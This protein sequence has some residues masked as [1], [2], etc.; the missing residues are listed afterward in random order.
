MLGQLKQRLAAGETTIGFWLNL[1]SSLE[2]EI[3]GITGYDWGLIDMEHGVGDLSG[4]VH[5][6]VALERHGVSPL[7]RIAACEPPLVKRVL[8][9]G[10]VGVMMPLVSTAED[11]ALAV[12]S[13]RYPPEGIRGV[14][15]STR[16]A[17]F[18]LGFS[19]YFERANRDLLTIVQV[20]TRE[21]VEN[22]EEIAGVEGV[23][24]LF[25][26]PRDLSTNLGTPS[27]MDSAPFREA[28]GKIEEA[29]RKSKKALGTI[30]TNPE[31]ARGLI[32][33][34]YGFIGVATTATLL[35]SSA[36]A[37][38]R[39]FRSDEGDLIHG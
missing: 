19:E 1:G 39:L 38:R 31:R 3:A 27:D 8:D 36:L 37:R 28:T 5:Q 30:A 21:A 32:E 22:I 9:L 25:I 24:V 29:A 2:A 23:D 33:R 15:G 7:V 11:A 4:L 34:G 10:V 13:M 6:V 20:E 18:G 26:G 16:A 17:R 14:A 35:A 12:R